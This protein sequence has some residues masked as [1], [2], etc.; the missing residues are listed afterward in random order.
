MAP[1]KPARVSIPLPHAGTVTVAGR[2]L[3]FAVE[4]ALTER[5]RTQGLMFRK[6]LGKGRG[7]V[8]FM[9]RDYDWSFYM[10]NTLIPLDMIFIDKAW[11]VVGVVA[12]V[13]PLTETL[14]SVGRPSR[15]VLELDAH[16]ARRNGLR[17]GTQLGYEGPGGAP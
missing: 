3:R 7:M 5:E 11:R 1:P 14:R 8:F 17:A 16:E 9:P 4:V 10:R 15:Y 13:P 6:R 2:P 12:N